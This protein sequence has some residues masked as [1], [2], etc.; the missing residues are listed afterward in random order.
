[1]N[2]QRGLSLIGLIVIGV[3]LALAAMVAMKVTPAVIE[4]YTIKKNIN[5][6]VQSGEAR[7]SVSDIRKAYDRR[8]QVD[9]TTSIRPDDLDISKSGGEVVI[10]V[11]Y[12]KKIPLFG[13]VSLCLDFEATTTPAKSRSIP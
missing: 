8:A 3:L 2:N 9:D 6:V 4:Y 7:G 1:M 10:S 11:A 13:N 5:A 12:A